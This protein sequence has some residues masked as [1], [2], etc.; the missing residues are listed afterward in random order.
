M[1]VSRLSRN[2]IHF[3]SLDA[4]LVI[5]GTGLALRCGICLVTD[6]RDAP[7]VNDELVAVR[8]ENGH[9]DPHGRAVMIERCSKNL[10]YLYASI[11]RQAK[12][13]YLARVWRPY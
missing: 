13:R 2:R 6:R 8:R 7:D 5:S 9:R 4:P 12:K 11:G 3:T 10:K 1:M